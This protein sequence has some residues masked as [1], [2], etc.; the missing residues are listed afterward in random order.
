MGHPN[1]IVL[2][3]LVKTG[4]LGN[5]NFRPTTPLS[6]FV[7]KLAKSKTLPFPTSVHRVSSCFKII[8]IDVWG[9]SSVVSYNCY[10][11]FVTFI[12]DYSHFTWIYFLHSKVFSMFKKFMT[13]VEAQFQSKIQT[14][15]SDFGDEY[16]SHEF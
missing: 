10:K 9:M 1:S 16:M 7:C 13:Y 15:R 6:C 12:D 2:S 14:F 8:H 3:H 4:L 11:Y 5:K